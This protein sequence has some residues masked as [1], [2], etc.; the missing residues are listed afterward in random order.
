MLRNGPAMILSDEPTGNNDPDRSETIVGSLDELNREAR[1]V[2]MVTHDLRAAR[3][4]LTRESNRLMN[5]AASYNMK[6][7]PADDSDF[8]YVQTVVWLFDAVNQERM[9]RCK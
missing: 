9:R 4:G 3:A 6:T 8:F 5:W 2:V 7:G 1:T